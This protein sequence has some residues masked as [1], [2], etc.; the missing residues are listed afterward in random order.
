MAAQ[1]SVRASIERVGTLRDRRLVESSGVAVSRS[2]PGLLWTHNDS[3]DGATIYAINLAGDLL[4]TYR[5][6][7]A[8]ANDWED[9][10]LAVCPFESSTQCLYISDT[11]D[12]SE[13]RK[14]VTIY[15]V[16]EP[17][18]P[19][20]SMKR[21]TLY[22]QRARALRVVYP[23]GP[24]DVEAVAVDAQGN[25]LLITKGWLGVIE[26]L[27]VSRSQF[28]RDTTRAVL[29]DTLPMDQQNGLGR[30][31]TGAAFSPSGDRLV[32]RTYRELYFYKYGRNGRLLPDGPPCWIG[33]VE[34][35]GEAVDFL[36]EHTLALTSESLRTQLGPVLRVS[37]DKARN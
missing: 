33:A 13:R 23:N 1:D 30:L 22:T 8:S 26:V 21:D 36:D 4:A 9:I 32:V 29:T 10:D 14:S 5:V 34:P 6:L 3:G 37:C 31:T 17:A 7:G 35:Q 11:G 16:P 15:V 27:R 18:P 25:A 28:S 19:T 12:N 20:D 24:R 2:H